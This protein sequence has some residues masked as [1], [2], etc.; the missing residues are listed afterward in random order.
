ML[1]INADV[2]IPFFLEHRQKRKLSH[3]PM[4]ELPLMGH[5]FLVV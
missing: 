2:D 5:R 1:N 4:Q 3:L